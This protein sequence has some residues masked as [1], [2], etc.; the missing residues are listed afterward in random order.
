MA[1]EQYVILAQHDSDSGAMP[2]IGTRDEVLAQLAPYNTAPDSED[3]NA[4]YGPG[5]IIELPPQEPVTQMLLT[6]VE[7]EI[8]W[9]VIM[10]LA[11]SLNWKLL[12]MASGREL[13][14]S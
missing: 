6:I 7:E 1:G 5:Y 9:Q 10:R 14:P 11:K 13:V 2:A 3:G 8:A 12:D 4:L